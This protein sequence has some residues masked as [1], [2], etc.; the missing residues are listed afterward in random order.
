MMKKATIA[1]VMSAAFCLCAGTGIAEQPRG[2]QVL[3]QPRDFDKAIE[4]FEMGIMWRMME[5]LD[6]D[7]ATAEKV[8]EVRRRFAAEQKGIFNELSREMEALRAKLQE[9]TAQPDE[10]KLLGIIKSIRDKRKRLESLR[11]RQYDEISQVLSVVQQAQLLIFT[12]EFQ[13]EIRAFIHRPLI[14]ASGPPRGG[15]PPPPPPGLGAGGDPFGGPP[16]F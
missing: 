14:P 10:K 15:G 16:D 11:D 5:A 6:M 1:M 2:R 12:K 4:H 7:R 9:E 3:G 13:D 8:F